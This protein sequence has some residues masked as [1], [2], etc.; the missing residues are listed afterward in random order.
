MLARINMIRQLVFSLVARQELAILW[1]LLWQTFSISA[2]RAKCKVVRWL[3]GRRSWPWPMAFYERPHGYMEKRLQPEKV[4]DNPL[5]SKNKPFPVSLAFFDVEWR[6]HVIA[7]GVAA[8][9]LVRSLTRQGNG[10]EHF[11]ASFQTRGPIVRP[12][13]W[14]SL[15]N[16]PETL[17]YSGWVRSWTGAE[18]K[19]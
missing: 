17:H 4:W 1:L 11:L 7:D 6:L 16:E 9:G 8:R 19:D 3:A 12:T 2:I 18:F 13:E 5:R 10:L 15:C 14:L